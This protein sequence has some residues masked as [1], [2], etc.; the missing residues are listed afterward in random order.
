MP[1]AFPNRGGKLEACD[2]MLAPL[3]AIEKY[4]SLRKDTTVRWRAKLRLSRSERFRSG[5]INADAAAGYA[6]LVS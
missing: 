2:L 1:L 5:P 3:A 6:H 4:Q